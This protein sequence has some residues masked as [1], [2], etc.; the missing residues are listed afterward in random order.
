MPPV[1]A[2]PGEP[3]LAV[4]RDRPYTLL[5]LLDTV[6]LRYMP[7]LSLVL[8]LWIAR[9]TAAPAWLVAR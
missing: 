7:L 9:H 5:T 1:P 6:M 2:R 8:P 3:A 4:P